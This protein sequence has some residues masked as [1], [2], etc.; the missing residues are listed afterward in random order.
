MNDCSAAIGWV[1]VMLG[2]QNQVDVDQCEEVMYRPSWG[3]WQ[4]LEKYGMQDI[5]AEAHPY[6]RDW[7]KGRNAILPHV[8][9]VRKLF[10]AI[11]FCIRPSPS[12]RLLIMNLLEAVILK[13][14]SS[15]RHVEQVW[16][17]YQMAWPAVKRWWTWVY[18]SRRPL[19]WGYL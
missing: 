4:H 5:D 14:S 13:D 2:I 6:R 1:H 19:P 17:A 15:Y 10:K 16:L 3:H 12:D 18:D 9:R 11:P 7:E 8:G